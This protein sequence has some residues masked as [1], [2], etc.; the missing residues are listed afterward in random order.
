MKYPDEGLNH[1]TDMWLNIKTQEKGK[2]NFW[3]GEITAGY[4]TND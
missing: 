4:G 2:K 3:F 1:D